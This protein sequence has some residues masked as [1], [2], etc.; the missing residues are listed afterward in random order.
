MSRHEPGS[1]DCLEIF[2]R[3]SE[4]LDEELDPVPCLEVDRHLQGCAPCQAFLES[5]RRTVALLEDVASPPVPDDLRRQVREAY[6][7][8]REDNGG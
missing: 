6:R 8:L 7:K 2:A 4:Y 5:L 3:L 1:T